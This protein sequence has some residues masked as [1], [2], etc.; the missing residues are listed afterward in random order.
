M[1]YHASQDS[2]FSHSGTDAVEDKGNAQDVL[3]T[4]HFRMLQKNRVTWPYL[5][6]FSADL[7]MFI[8]MWGP[9][10]QS[11]NICQKV[12][13]S[14]NSEVFLTFSVVFF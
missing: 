13:I 7:T 4:A 8:S 3:D 10:I 12:M 6:T 9:H 1:K 14:V 2:M 5:L 11:R